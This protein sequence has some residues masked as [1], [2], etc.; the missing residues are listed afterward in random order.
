MKDTAGGAGPSNHVG[1]ALGVDEGNV[2]A[3]K[4]IK[5][6]RNLSTPKNHEEILQT[7]IFL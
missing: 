4:K 1:H 7:P 2:V 6:A 3:E 5:K